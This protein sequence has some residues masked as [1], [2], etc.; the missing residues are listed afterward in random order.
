MN[1]S[2]DGL[3]GFD[4]HGKTVGVIGTGRI[5]KVFCQIM[6]GFG[7]KVLAYDT[8]PD[9]K[10]AAESG[11]LYF[12]RQQLFKESD[13]LS[14]HIPLTAITRHIIDGSA[15]DLMKKNL[16]IIN[17]GRGALIDTKALIRSLK[18]HSIGGACL[19]VYEEESGIF[20]SDLSESGIDDDLLARLLTFP[21]VLLTSHQAFLTHEAL[22]NIADTTIESIT[23]FEMGKDLR[24]VLVTL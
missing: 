5:G 9:K 14:L 17:T 23:R 11:V 20:F 3:V 2:L 16:V 15:I 13:I 12:D 22:I 10:W 18:S 21:N 19:D 8:N 4:L 6:R 24:K 1:F 7:C